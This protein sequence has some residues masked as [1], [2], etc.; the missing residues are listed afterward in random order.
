MSGV[1]YLIKCEEC[2]ACG[3]HDRPLADGEFWLCSF[4][5]AK[6]ERKLANGR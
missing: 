2:G 5:Q 6:L 3:L 1:R 4:H